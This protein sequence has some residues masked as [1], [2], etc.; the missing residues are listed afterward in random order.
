MLP[1]GKRCYRAPIVRAL[2]LHGPSDLRLEE[3]PDPT[4]GPG[5]IVV[6]V[7]R[8][9]TCATDAKMLRNGSHPALPALP[10]LFGHELAGTVDAV[11]PDERR[12]A[13][14]DRVVVVNSAPCGECRRCRRGRPNLCSDIR[15]L[16]GAFAERV[17]VPARIAAVNVLKIP[18][19]VRAEEAALTEPMACALHGAARLAAGPEDVVM[20][21][22]GGFQGTV[23]TA[24]LARRGCRVWMC[25]PHE[26]RR[27]RALSF[28]AERAWPAAR[29]AEVIAA[30]REATP[31]G[32]GADAVVEAVGRPETWSAAVSLAAPGGEV[33]LHGGCAIGTE[34]S[35]PTRPL[36]YDELRLIGSYHHTP[37]AVRDALDLI[38]EGALPLG[39]LLGGEVA[40]EEV[41]AVLAAGGE[42]RPVVT[43]A[44]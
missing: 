30:L 39:E 38:T 17:L 25:D 9:L 3:E 29:T 13:E 28:G 26:E 7:D 11:A 27:A 6:R 31:E 18:D 41:P 20:V 40:L 44:P 4:P 22:G 10:S 24:A 12:F 35:L 16:F 5:E 36:H 14:G 23:V 43:A 2:R 42:K 32:V 19:G 1:V 37:A 33:L 21:L 8:A 15:Y 34:V